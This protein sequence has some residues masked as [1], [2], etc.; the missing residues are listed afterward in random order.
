MDSSHAVVPP[1]ELFHSYAFNV[2]SVDDAY[3]QD[4]LP[5]F[6]KHDIDQSHELKEDNSFP[7]SLDDVVH[8]ELATMCRDGH[9]P[10]K[11]FDDIL[12][13]AQRA[14]LRG[15]QFPTSAPSHETFLT[16]L[17]HR[18]EMDHVNH[19]ISTVVL[20]GGGTLSL[21]IF[22]FVTMF[23][24]LLDDSRIRP[25]LMINWDHPRKPPKFDRRF[26]NEIHSG[27]WHAKTSRECLHNPSDVLC[28]LIFFID[29]THVA[30]KD[31]LSLCPVLFSLSIIPQ[32]LRVHSFAWR[33][34]G[35]IRKIPPSNVRGQ[36]SINYHR[37]LK[38]ALQGIVDAQKSGGIT[39]TIP[40][41]EGQGIRLN[42]KVP[43][44]TVG[45]FECNSKLKTA[46][47]RN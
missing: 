9:F 2:D 11:T 43:V 21:P 26:Y 18:L 33:P 31:R 30:L 14:H 4:K 22:D 32:W 28:G 29:R 39:C 27:T 46:Q 24:S 44:R 36:R 25:Y 41:P 40:N 3:N 8:L 15:Y 34:L 7:S 1:D 12:R 38:A 5:A 35:F 42:F 6:D 16:K 20:D 13:W 19:E 10:L 37:M 47:L 17:A 23:L 45:L